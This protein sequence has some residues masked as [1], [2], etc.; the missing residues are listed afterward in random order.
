MIDLAKPLLLE[1]IKCRNSEALTLR[2]DCSNRL[3]SETA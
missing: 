3:G 1:I 2:R